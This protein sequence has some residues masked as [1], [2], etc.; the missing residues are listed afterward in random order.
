MSTQQKTLVSV[1]KNSHDPNSISLEEKALLNNMSFEVL[2]KYYEI[3][4]MYGLASFDKQRKYEDGTKSS[5]VFDSLNYEGIEY[6]QNPF[7][8]KKLDKI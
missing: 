3:C 5:L 8:I 1:L 7:S 6:M 2:Q 4:R